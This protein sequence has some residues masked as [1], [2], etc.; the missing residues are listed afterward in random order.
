M[1]V[2]TKMKCPIC[3]GE[4]TLAK[5]TVKLFDGLIVLRDDPI[6]KCAK[7]GE[8]FATGKIV[9]ESAKRAK[10]R[11]TFKR[12]I[13]S[14]GGSLGITFPPDI[15]EYYKLSKSKNVSIIPE[16]KNTIKIITHD[17]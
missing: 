10:K 13:I 2:K 11:F 3:E 6:Y 4:A 8:Q 1:A 15:T 14:T 16:N 5:A 12:R 9:E 7:C 17:T